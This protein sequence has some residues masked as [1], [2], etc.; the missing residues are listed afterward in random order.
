MHIPVIPLAAEDDLLKWLDA[1][2]N[3]L[4]PKEAWSKW[5]DLLRRIQKPL[6]ENAG[7]DADADDN[8]DDSNEDNNLIDVDIFDD[9]EPNTFDETIYTSYK[10]YNFLE[11]NINSAVLDVKQKLAILTEFETLKNI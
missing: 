10:C 9:T 3:E 11:E 2:F 7:G 6:A 8:D 1:K 5:L 4:A